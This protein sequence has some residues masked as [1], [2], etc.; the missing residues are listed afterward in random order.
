MPPARACRGQAV[1]FFIPYEGGD[2][3]DAPVEIRDFR[4]IDFTD[5]ADPNAF[6]IRN[7]TQTSIAS[8]S[9]DSELSVATY[10]R[11]FNFQRE[12]IYKSKQEYTSTN[13]R[14]Q[15]AHNNYFPTTSFWDDDRSLADLGYLNIPFSV[16]VGEHTNASPITNPYA[17]VISV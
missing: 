1:A 16:L 14:D 6:P 17:N 5:I 3:N 13:T 8:V 7:A 10:N 9:E 11:R 12:V 15:L 4:V 2:A